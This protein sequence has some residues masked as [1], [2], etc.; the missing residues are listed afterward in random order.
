VS[1]AVRAAI[2]AYGRAIAAELE[3]LTGVEVGIE[4]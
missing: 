1:R 2:P 4:A 3:S